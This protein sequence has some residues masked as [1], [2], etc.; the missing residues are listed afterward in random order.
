MSYSFGVPADGGGGGGDVSQEELDAVA[1]AAL[2]KVA[3]LADLEDAAEAKTNL[4]LVKADVGLGNVDNTS[5]ANKPVSSATQTALNLKAPIASPTFTGTVAGVTKGMVG[6]GNVDNTADSAKPVSTATQTALD[7]K[8]PLAR[9]EIF[10]N[11]VDYGATPGGVVDCSA[12]FQAA[13]D[14]MKV[15]GGT[16]LVPSGDWL[17]NTTLNLSNIHPTY[18]PETRPSLT[19]RG[20]GKNDTV[21]LGGETGFGFM[22]LVGS[23]RLTV[24]GMTLKAG[25]G[26]QYAILAGR[27]TGDGN[28]GA[29]RFSDITIH[30]AYSVAALFAMSSEG[31]RYDDIIAYITDGCAV[32]LAR[33]LRGWSG[34]A[35]KY[36]PLSATTILSGGNGVISMR[37]C[38]LV[39][40]GPDDTD[41]PLTIEYVQTFIGDSIYTLSTGA[42]L[43]VVDKGCHHAAF[44]GLHQ[45]WA[46]DWPGA[47]EPYGIY[48][49]NTASGAAP[50]AARLSIESSS[51]YAVYGE[52]GVTFRDFEF[53]SSGWR[54]TK[55]YQ[56]DVDL[57]V[58][59]RISY[60]PGG[61]DTHEVAAPAYRQRTGNPNPLASSFATTYTTAQTNTPYV[62]PVGAKVLTVRAQ[63][64]GAGGGSGRRGAASTLRCGGGGGGAGAYSGEWH[65]SVPE[66]TAAGVT[67][68]YVT[69]G[70]GGTGGAAQTADDT[71]GNPGTG[72]GFSAVQTAAVGGSAANSLLRVGASGGGAGGTAVGGTGGTGG[73]G[74]FS[75]PAGAAA[76]GSGTAGL[77]PGAV[78]SA[79]GGGGSGGGLTAANAQAAGGGGGVALSHFPVGTSGGTAGGGAGVA[80]GNPPAVIGHGHGGGG[81][82]SNL[83]GAGGAGGAGGYGAGGGG[84]GASVNGSAS[85]AGGAGGVGFVQFVA[86]F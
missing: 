27:T 69:V 82:G 48:A 8:A 75:G 72:G 15:V 10:A 44:R 25:T 26:L 81:G 60:H 3:N 18:P 61:V 59:N 84:G 36:T 71:D 16:V 58:N 66:L 73:T 67:T 83:T 5:D 68:L 14:D 20:N 9:P 54:G 53:R 50:L 57:A 7:L 41:V 49:K 85:G 38:N 64:G 42:P 13:I 32:V 63:A 47:T 1:A 43:I 45:E 21:L 34:A 17:I 46:S 30:G 86:L 76:S 19:L 11:V 55:T 29:H 2:Q 23:N 28:A 80:G 6:L 77:T 56:F 65:F 79:P 31:C 37:R 4:A 52:D 51:V 40:V 24:E 70:G 74:R 62:I 35:A 33:D 39:T 22:E 12:A 78:S